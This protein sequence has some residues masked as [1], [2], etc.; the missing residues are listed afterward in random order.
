MKQHALPLFFF[1][2]LG[3][4]AFGAA[5]DQETHE[6][7]FDLGDVDGLQSQMQ[8]EFVWTNPYPRDVVISQILSSCACTAVKS[9]LNTVAPGGTTKLTMVVDL[10]QLQGRSTTSFVLVFQDQELR[11]VSFKASFFVM[12]GLV[13]YP[14]EVNFGLIHT[15]E[16][17]SYEFCVIWM[18]KDDKSWMTLR[19][20]QIE[21]EGG[22]AKCELIDRRVRMDSGKS[23]GE[24]TKIQEFVFRCHP[25]PNWLGTRSDELIIPFESAD[26]QA[27]C[28]VP[29]KGQFN[30]RITAMPNAIVLF[31]DRIANAEPLYVNLLSH[32]DGDIR[33]IDA[34]TDSGVIQ[35]ALVDAP[36]DNPQSIGRVRITLPASSQTIKTQIQVHYQIHDQ[37]FAITLPVRII[38]PNASSAN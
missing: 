32:I 19:N 17:T 37:Q 30:G 9:S 27:V 24:Q 5:S 2:V 36:D 25:M 8:A 23:P 38:N 28:R 11:P 15:P 3:A 1:V 18:A 33:L 35:S 10:R 22:L 13:A 14:S 4:S 31:R 21:S 20:E 16:Q 29:V 34:I 7:A 6:F 26:R 12:S